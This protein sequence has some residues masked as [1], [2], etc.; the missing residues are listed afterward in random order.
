[1]AKITEAT[2]TVT[3]LYSLRSLIMPEHES[4][5]FTMDL[6]KMI[7]QSASQMLAWAMRWKWGIYDSM[8]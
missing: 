6:S 1:M 5:Y 2:Q 3:K 4:R 7:E 8:R